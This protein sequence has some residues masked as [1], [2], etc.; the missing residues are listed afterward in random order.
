LVH[1]SGFSTC[2]KKN[3]ATLVAAVDVT[4]N[5]QLTYLQTP[6]HFGLLRHADQGDLENGKWLAFKFG[7]RQKKTFF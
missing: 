5:I 1:F 3:L 6:F 7:A 2:A 4:S